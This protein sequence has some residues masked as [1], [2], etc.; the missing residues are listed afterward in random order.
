[1]LLQIKLPRQ[2]ITFELDLPLLVIM[3]LKRVFEAPIIL[4]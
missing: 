3:Q 1:M 2:H 4:L